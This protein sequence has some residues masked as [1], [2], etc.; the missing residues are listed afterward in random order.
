MLPFSLT[1]NRNTMGRYK[2]NIFRPLDPLRNRRQKANLEEGPHWLRRLK[3]A[4]LKK[5]EMLADRQII[6]VKALERR[7]PTKFIGKLTNKFSPT[8]A[9]FFAPKK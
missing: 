1:L 7:M 9:K 8:F 3:L 2:L 5:M 6:P 4:L